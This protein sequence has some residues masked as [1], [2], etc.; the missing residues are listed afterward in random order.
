MLP[1]T[2]IT[3]N[4]SR[5]RSE[6][7]ATAIADSMASETDLSELL[8]SSVF[9]YVGLVAFCP[10]QLCREKFTTLWQCV[11]VPRPSGP[12]CW[13]STRRRGPPPPNAFFRDVLVPQVHVPC[14]ARTL[15]SGSTPSLACTRPPFFARAHAPG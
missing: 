3:S 8:T 7:D 12:T 15:E 13:G 11:S 6:R 5:L 14:A 1:R 2:S 9:T 10:S 4:H